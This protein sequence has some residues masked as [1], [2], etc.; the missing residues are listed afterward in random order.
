MRRKQ[1]SEGG[2][3]YVYVV[4]ADRK[5]AQQLWEFGWETS[6]GAE[7]HLKECRQPPTDP[8]YGNQL[9]VYRVE[10]PKQATK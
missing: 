8:H 9:H 1:E 3:K 10:V 4:A 6:T 2:V 7:S 5:E